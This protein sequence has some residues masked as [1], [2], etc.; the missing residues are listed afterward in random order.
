MLTSASDPIRVDFLPLPHLSGRVGLTFAPG[1]S[2]GIHWNRNLGD[3]LDRLS[4][5]YRVAHLVS[6]IE[7]HEHET[8]RIENLYDEAARRRIEV[9]RL[10]IRD[11]SVP[12][13]VACV[14]PLVKSIG[15]WAS[16]AQTVAIHCIGGLGRTGTIAGCFLVEQGFAAEEALKLL[17]EVRASNCPETAEQRR[18][19]LR[20]A[21]ESA[22]ARR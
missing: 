8:Y 3:D 19:V 16:D 4:E 15:A 1:K 14:V 12:A 17:G 21:N 18:F 2:D 20:Y 9:H 6:L 7:N 10:P 5:H 13:S 22:P 11:V